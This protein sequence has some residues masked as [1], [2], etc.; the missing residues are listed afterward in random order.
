MKSVNIENNFNLGTDKLILALNLAFADD[1]ILISNNVDNIGVDANHRLRFSYPSY[2][3][4]S[5]YG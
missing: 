5:A 3:T 1:M 4:L 2:W